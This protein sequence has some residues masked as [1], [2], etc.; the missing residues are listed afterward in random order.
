MF[1]IARTEG[2]GEEAEDDDVVRLAPLVL[3][4]QD[5]GETP[6]VFVYVSVT[7]VNT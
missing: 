6:V 3:S 2:Q 4:Q 1:Y 5:L 7:R